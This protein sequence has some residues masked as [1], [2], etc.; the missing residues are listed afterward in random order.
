MY[1]LLMCFGVLWSWVRSG[2]RAHLSLRSVRGTQHAPLGRLQRAW[3][4]NL[5]GLLE[6]GRDPGHHAERWNKGEPRQDLGDALPVHLESFQRPV[7]LWT[8]SSL[9]TTTF[10]DSGELSLHPLTQKAPTH[11]RYGVDHA[12]GDLILP[13]VFDHVELCCSLFGNDLVC[14]LLQ[15]WVEFLKEIFKEQRQKLGGTERDT[16]IFLHHKT[17]NFRH[18]VTISFWFGLSRHVMPP[19]VS[20]QRR[21]AITIRINNQVCQLTDKNDLASVPGPIPPPPDTQE[22]TSLINTPT[23][24][25]IHQKQTGSSV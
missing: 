25:N 5:P 24:I 11:G 9:P 7:A 19:S 12:V 20:N 6:L 18:K 4:A 21:A 15:L 16:E 13:H 2:W 3:P 14:D 23:H 22:G 8:E 1:L 17:A 10:V